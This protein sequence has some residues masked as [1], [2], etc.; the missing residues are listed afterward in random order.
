MREEVGLVP[1]KNIQ[2]MRSVAKSEVARWCWEEAGS[3]K[4]KP[5]SEIST[6]DANSKEIKIALLKYQTAFGGVETLQN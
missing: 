1:G 5:E 2:K 4:T 3:R 6:P